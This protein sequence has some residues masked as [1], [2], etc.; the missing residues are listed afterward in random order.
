MRKDV[1]QIVTDRIIALLESGTVPWKKPWKGGEMPQNVV[2]RKPYRGVNVF[3]LNATWFTSPFWLSFRQ[4]QSIGGSVRKGERAF[5]VVF[6]KMLDVEDSDRKQGAKEHRHVPLLRYY[7][8][9]NVEQCENIKPSLL[10]DVETNQFKPLERC[11][12]LVAAM[13]KRPDIVHNGGRAAYCP[14]R[15]TVTM[16]KTELFNSPEAYYNT[17]FHEL[18]HSTGH[19]SRLNRKEITDPIRFGSDPYSREELVAE[20]GAAFLSGHCRIEHRTIA[21]SAAYIQ[22]WLGRL[23]NDRKL[24]VHAAAQAQKAVDF[25]L[26]RAFTESEAGHD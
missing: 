14:L 26:G 9:F 6:W 15:D 4:V 20:V 10:P 12:R 11:D 19:A 22:G 21:E 17:L 18:T 25:I 23:R 24:I 7:K 13:P 16:P 2:S 5:L 8:V 1:Y 3:L